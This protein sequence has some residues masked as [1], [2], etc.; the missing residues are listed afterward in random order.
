M[1][2]S[3]RFASLVVLTTYVNLCSKRSSGGLALPSHRSQ[4]SKR[5]KDNNLSSKVVNVV[6]V[7]WLCPATGANVVSEAKI[8]TYVNTS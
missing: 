3:A 6:A 7:G 8:T 2:A 1:L 4:R 5:S